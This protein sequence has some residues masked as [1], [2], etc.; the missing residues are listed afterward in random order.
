MVVL[1][2]VA[3]RKDNVPDGRLF[4]AELGENAPSKRRDVDA[5]PCESVL[6][7]VYVHRE[8]VETKASLA[9]I[10]ADINGKIDQHG[11]IVL[12]SRQ[13]L[14]RPLQPEWCVQ[15]HFDEWSAV[16]IKHPAYVW[17]DEQRTYFDRLWGLREPFHYQEGDC[18]DEF[19]IS[20][21]VPTPL[22]EPE[23]RI[24]ALIETSGDD[25]RLEC[26]CHWTQIVYTT[27]QRVLCMGCG[28]LLCVLAKPLNGPF[29]NKISSTAW[30]QAFDADGELIDDGITIDLVGYR[31][32]EAAAKLW[33]TDVWDEVASRIHFYATA[34]RAEIDRFH[35]TC[36]ASPSDLMAAGFS[37]RLAPPSLGDQLGLRDLELDLASNAALSLNTA[38]CAY[39]KGKG[40]PDALRDAVLSTFHSAELL[41]KLRLVRE[42][43]AALKKNPNNPSV[44]KLL[45][46]A[47]VAFR[48]DE[49]ATLTALRQLRNKLQH[50]GATISY[51]STRTL[52]RKSF[53]MLDRFAAEE[54]GV[55]IGS[56]C[57]S[58]G[59]L[60]LLS[61]N[62]IRTR[63]LE[64]L[65]RFVAE[66]R[67][68]GESVEV[69][70]TCGEEGLID[71]FEGPLCFYCRD[72][73]APKR[74]LDAD[75]DPAA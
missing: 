19:A 17:G 31:E 29:Q 68:K 21:Y 48:V 62:R 59:W 65:Q 58:V 41:L 55:W 27:S 30:I 74:I 10:I 2:V 23:E 26:P 40:D 37:E 13:F 25:V 63:A 3:G 6:A 56:V 39:D 12:S 45:T 1:A 60:S 35:R 61:I 36:F 47:G 67:A 9:Q 73:P 52:L 5:P 70:G 75:D 71:T 69:C 14:R 49:T 11:G 66:C 20:T 42:D 33:Q 50:S 24:C 46:E 8:L 64:V 4:V 43:N 57:D 54:L 7:Y 32:V 16:P 53:I 51:R 44:L 15:E 28:Q 34:S 18:Y 72:R 22:L 38:A